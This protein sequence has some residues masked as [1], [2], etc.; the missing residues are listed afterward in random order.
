M[1]ERA[2]APVRYSVIYNPVAGSGRSV[3]VAATVGEMLE[4]RG[5]SVELMASER[6]GHIAALSAQTD[7][8]RV[9]VLGGDGSLREAAAGLLSRTGSLPELGILPFGTGNVVARELG[10][11][12]N[13]ERA[14]EVMER[15]AAVAFD[16]GWASVEGQS[17]EVFL[18]MLGV[19]Y[20]AAVAMRIGKARATRLGGALYKRSAGALY[21]AAGLR[22]LC[23]LSPPR[24]RVSMDGEEVGARAVAAVLSNTETY[25]KGMAMSPG[26]SA[27][28]G[29]FDLHLRSSASPLVEA[30][31]LASA[32][33][34]RSGPAW[35]CQRSQGRGAVLTA[36]DP[37]RPVA[38]QLD[39]DPLGA[40][41]EITVTM[42]AGALRLIGALPGADRS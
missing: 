24:F 41:D 32:Q 40:A 29:L 5:H 6:P 7:A 18:A 33:F 37:S 9:L 28:D 31:A 15:S 13:P 20:D 19:G 35:A 30:V 14:A 2:A 27:A 36:I 10:L 17:P 26:A 23:A 12:L 38:W 22:E 42:Q 11:P 39:G 16:V 8:D 25:G 1:T 34:R 3:G 21:A 4:A